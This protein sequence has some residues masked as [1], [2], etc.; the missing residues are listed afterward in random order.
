MLGT[1][2]SA[3]SAESFP[4]PTGQYLPDSPVPS[5]WDHR[6]GPFHLETVSVHIQTHC[7]VGGRGHTD[8]K[9]WVSH[10]VPCGGGGSG[11]R[12]VC[13]SPELPARLPL[14]LRTHCGVSSARKRQKGS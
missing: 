1:R 13:R 10:A 4:C 12:K 6:C 3:S 9:G 11:T 7:R 2:G 14:G 5:L 8:P